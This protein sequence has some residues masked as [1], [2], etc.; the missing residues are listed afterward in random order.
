MTNLEKLAELYKRKAE[1]GLVDV[2]FAFKET[3][4][5]ASAEELAGEILAMEEAIKAG[6]S[7]PLDFGDYSL[8]IPRR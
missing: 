8:N 4:K 2:S 6:K 3:A 1:Q 5:N 7:T